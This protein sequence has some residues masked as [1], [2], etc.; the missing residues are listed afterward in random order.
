MAKH[1][2]KSSKGKGKAKR[3]SGITLQRFQISLFAE[4]LPKTSWFSKPSPYAKVEV[5]GGPQDGTLLGQTEAISKTV[6]PDWCEILFVETAPEINMPLRV[7]VWDQRGDDS[8]DPI[9]MATAEFEATSVYQSQGKNSTE[10]IG[11]RGKLHI[12]I[13]ESFVGD[14][15]GKMKLQLR[16]L[17]MKNVEPGPF[18]LGRSDPFFEIAKKNADHHIAQVNWNVVYRSEHIDNNLNPYWDP[19]VID[20]EKLCFGREDWPLKVSVYDHNEDGNHVLIGA[21]ETNIPHL[22]SRISIKGNADRDQ[23]ILLAQEV[24]RN[25]TYGLLCVIKAELI[26]EGDIEHPRVVASSVMRE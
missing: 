14:L 25:K 7:T 8:L 11:K 26:A 5:I 21:F 10:D 2:R 17:D 24:K 1:K 12:H 19:T 15:R 23:A 18:G 22:Q 13:E 3:D 9:L 4:N 16:G 20:L 6:S